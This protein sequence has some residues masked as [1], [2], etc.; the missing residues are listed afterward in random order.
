VSPSR[1][2]REQD[3]GSDEPGR[4]EHQKEEPRRGGRS[5]RAGGAD[6]QRRA[7]DEGARRDEQQSGDALRP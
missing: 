3:G 6:E 4:V 1:R 7:G 2:A 5:I